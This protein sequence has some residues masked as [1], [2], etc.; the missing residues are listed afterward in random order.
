MRQWVKY[1]LSSLLVLAGWASVALA[2]DEEEK[3][4]GWADKAEL[5]FVLASG[6][7][8]TSTLGFRNL[9][10]HIWP[11][12]ELNFEVAGLRTET[13]TITRTPVGFTGEDFV[14]EKSSESAVTA[15]NYQARGK[16][17]R[18][19]SDRLY[20]F[21]SGGWDRDE[22]A[23]V[24]NRTYGAGGIGTIWYEQEGLRWRTDYGISVTNEEPTV[25]SSDTYA[26]LRL[27]SDFMRQLSTSTSVENL[28][29]A[30]E[31]LNETDDLRI[32]CLTGLSVNM[33][34]HLAIK[35]S[36]RFLFDNVPSFTEVPL[37][38]PDRVLT[39]ILVPVQ[40]DKLDTLLS[41]AVVLDF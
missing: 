10:S 23:G 25:G 30:N 20:A 32:D 38:R 4:L 19:L 21:G 6:N 29:I 33:V 14:V 28:T 36:L 41:L 26:G 40:T 9:L 13:S 39:G 12:A 18:N 37:Q 2:Q 5:A 11:E 24:R 3:K 31:N 34:E 7:S 27:S 15:E 22:F 8:E 17:D 35:L 1:T 16:Y